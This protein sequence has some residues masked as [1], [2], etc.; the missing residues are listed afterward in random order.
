MAVRKWLD[1]SQCLPGASGARAIDVGADEWRQVALD[2]AAGGGQ[3][4]A[5]WAEN[6]D[7]GGAI[8]HFTLPRSDEE[9]LREFADSETP[10]AGLAL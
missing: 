10:S 5:L 7:E 4:Y 2:V 8:F 1:R 9:A 6:R 3:L